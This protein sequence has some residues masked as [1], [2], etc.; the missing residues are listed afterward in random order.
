MPQN[1]ET[2][3]RASR[4]GHSNGTVIIKQLGG[5]NRK[6]GSNEFDLGDERVSLHSSRYRH[7]KPQSVGVTLKCLKHVKSV[8]GAFQEKNGSYLILKLTAKE[9]TDASRPTAS[10]GASSGRVVVVKR[11]IFEDKGKRIAVIQAEE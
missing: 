9:F 8:L 11:S 7:G 1:R 3:A 4:F 2:G 6:A 5:T 10:R